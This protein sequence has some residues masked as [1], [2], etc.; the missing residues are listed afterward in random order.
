M[1]SKK[2]GGGIYGRRGEGGKRE[3]W[4]KRKGKDEKEIPYYLD[5]FDTNFIIFINVRFSK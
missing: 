4:K 3:E 1:E 2:L 5:G